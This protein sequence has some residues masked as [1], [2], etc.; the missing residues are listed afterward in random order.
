MDYDPVPAPPEQ[1]VKEPVRRPVK[2]LMARHLSSQWVITSEEQLDERL[3]A[4][5]KKILEELNN[6]NDVK[7]QF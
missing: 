4:F 2:V 1:V 3:D 5:K 7:V 6:G